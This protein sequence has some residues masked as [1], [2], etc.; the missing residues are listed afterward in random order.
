MAPFL[1]LLP[2]ILPTHADDEIVIAPTGEA[3]EA[4]DEGGLDVSVSAELWSESGSA[5]DAV[6]GR[7]HYR[8]LPDVR[9]T[10]GYGGD[11]ILT[12]RAFSA[13]LRSLEE[14][15]RAEA[16][17]EMRLAAHHGGDVKEVFNNIGSALAEYGMV[18]E[19]IGYYRRATQLEHA[20]AYQ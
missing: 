4:E 10:P 14:R 11:A 7:Y 15:Q 17:R 2:L 5:D 16:L 12:D 13:A 3:P 20:Y 1:L 9:P 18:N 19:A 6:W 8:N